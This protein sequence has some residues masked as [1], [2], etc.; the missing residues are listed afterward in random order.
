[1]KKLLAKHNK[2]LIIDC[3]SFSS[4]GQDYELTKDA[5]RPQICLYAD[6]FHTPKA[7]LDFA[8]SAFEKAGFEVAIN[9]P[10][11]GA[12]TP[13]KFYEKD[14]RV[15]SLMIE[16]RRDLYMDETTGRLRGDYLATK[17]RLNRACKQICKYFNQN[18]KF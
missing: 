13:S 8:K 5:Y 11:A 16:V 17:A 4:F 18:I 10:F 12:I 3:H 9:T 15:S 14:S 2:C 6:N 7:L 1:M